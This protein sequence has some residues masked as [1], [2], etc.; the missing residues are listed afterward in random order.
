[1]TAKPPSY[2]PLS[3]CQA[4]VDKIGGPIVRNGRDIR[5]FCPAHEA[6]G[7]RHNPS[8]AAWPRADGSVAF[9]C[10][11]CEHTILR[12]ALSKLG[13]LPDQR[14]SPEEYAKRVT[15]EREART[16]SKVK[17][18]ELLDGAH[19]IGEYSPVGKY[20]ASRKIAL[21]FVDEGK[22]LFQK[23]P[24]ASEK[25]WQFLNVFV[26][27]STI[28]Q[29]TIDARGVQRLRIDSDGKAIITPRGKKDRHS[30][31]PLRGAAVPLGTPGP[32]VLIGEGV[33]TVLAAMR[34]LNI[35]FALAALSA[36]NLCVAL[37]RGTQRV[38][39]VADND[40]GGRAGAEKAAA[41][42][43]FLGVL[44]KVTTL[45]DEGE[46]AGDALMRRLNGG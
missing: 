14:L 7:A 6:D 39:I 33:E 2:T 22:F 37:P 40:T 17:A 5:C 18:A 20:L 45:G 23:A 32:R 27:P 21:R 36:D 19:P 3:L 4:I 44:T 46:D 15:A 1:M 8:F 30:W 31:G 38:V 13:L 26:D 25:H 12:D 9:N 10:F 11:S 34:L 43:R 29:P 42:Y 24:D 35:N 41:Q 28:F 16:A